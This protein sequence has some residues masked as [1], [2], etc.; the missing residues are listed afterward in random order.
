MSGAFLAFLLA[1][2]RIVSIAPTTTEILYGVGAFD[3]VVAVSD[4]CTYPPEVKSLPRVGGW[5]TPSLER[6]VSLR[7]D[8]VVLTEAQTPF[9]ADELRQLGIPMLVTRSQTIAHT[10]EAIELVGRAV[11]KEREGRALAAATRATLESV[12]ARARNLPRP[13]VLCVVDRTPGTLRDIYAATRG[14][15]LT[16]LIE[17]AGGIPVAAPAP[18]EYGKIDKEMVLALNPDVIFDLMPGSSGQSA[19]GALAAWSDLPELNA[20]RT[21]RVFPITEEFVPHASQMIAETAVLFAR[22]LHPEV[23]AKE[24]KGR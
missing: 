24:W 10:L 7:P 2:N 17:A 23:P 13:K 12:R 6:L 9:I 14:S 11:G 1:A 3:R 20:V 5:H 19:K 16:E 22:L 18:L 4:Y 21:R 8:L 15:F